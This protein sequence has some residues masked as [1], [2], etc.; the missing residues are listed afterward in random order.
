MYLLK[1]K[2]TKHSVKEI[3]KRDRYDLKPEDEDVKDFLPLYD[4]SFVKG[5]YSLF[6]EV[7]YWRKFNALHSWFVT[8]VQIGVD[9]CGSYEVSQDHIDDLLLTLENTLA[10]RDPTNM[11]PVSGFFFGSTIVDEY[12]WQNMEDT[13]DKIYNISTTFDWEK[14]RLFY[15]SSW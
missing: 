1:T 4:S 2:K 7:A 5:N 11:M 9:D 6:E 10:Y 14:E 15:M 12:Y 8:N 13:Y 3:L